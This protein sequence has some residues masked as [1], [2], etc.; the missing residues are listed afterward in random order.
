MAWGLQTSPR[1]I[2]QQTDLLDRPLSLALGPTEESRAMPRPIRVWLTD[3]QRQLREMLAEMLE[4]HGLVC[5]HQCGSAEML[6]EDLRTHAPPDLVVVDIN[7]GG[8]TGVEALPHIRRLVPGLRALILTTFAD[9]DQETAAMR[10]GASGLL[11]KS[12]GP[13]VVARRIVAAMREPPM[14]ERAMKWEGAEA[15]AKSRQQA[16]SP[17]PAKPGGFW[18]GALGFWSSRRSASM[19]SSRQSA[20]SKLFPS[21]QR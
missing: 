9:M 5:E 3:D 18:K 21:V 2:E 10:A 15:L 20:G 13:V 11:R 14:T 4:D 6:L 19:G 16:E 1:M 7:M 8:M 12:E 17:A